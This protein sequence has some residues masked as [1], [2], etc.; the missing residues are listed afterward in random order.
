MAVPPNQIRIP[1]D[2][3]RVER[4]RGQIC[5]PMIGA[6]LG[7]PLGMREGAG[8]RYQGGELRRFRKVPAATA[9]T[10]RTSRSATR[11]HYT[12]PSA[13]LAPRCRVDFLVDGVGVEVKRGKPDKRRLAEQ[14]R[15]YLSQ[16]ALEALILVVDTH[17]DLPGELCG[18]PVAVVALNRLWGIALP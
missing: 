6:R 15:R 11:A 4:L 16:D 13:R 7:L 9:S 3:R 17:V 8:G 1:R 18:K 10:R 14:C 5:A 12:A 2:G